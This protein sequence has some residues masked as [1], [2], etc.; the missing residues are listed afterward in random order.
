[1]KLQNLHNGVISKMKVSGF[2]IIKNAL[3]Y[4]YPVVE[5]IQS[6]LPLVDEM[7]VCAGD[8]EDDTNKLIESIGSEKIRIVHSVWQKYTEGG[9][10]LAVETNKAM[11]AVAADSDWLFYIQADEVLHEDYL[12]VIK[13]ALEKYKNDKSVDGL[14]FHYHHF[15]GSYRYIG[16]SRKW[17]SKEIRVIRNKKTIRSYRDAQGFRKVND[18]K[19]RVKLI[20]AWI[21]H[22]GWVRN[23]VFMQRKDRDFGQFWNDEKSQT[24]WAEYIDR[25]G[26]EYDYSVIDSLE[27]YKGTHPALMKKRVQSENWDFRFDIKKKNFKSLKHRLLYYFEKWTGIRPF[28][29]SNYKRI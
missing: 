2:T 15:Y 17:Y 26:Q 11:D 16:D 29:Y 20:D 28:E 8:S 18:E 5:S 23:P 7:I 21:H 22:Y 10:A 19:L 1:M 12:P 4:D 13:A 3:K 9:A 27:M 25:K 14:L 6:I 24:A